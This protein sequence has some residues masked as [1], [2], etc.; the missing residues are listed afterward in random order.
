MRIALTRLAFTASVWMVDRVHDDPA[1][2]GTAP[3]PTAPPRLSHIYVLMFEV[4]YLA[5]RGHAGCQDASHLSGLEPYLH[6]IAVTAHYLSK[7]SGAA[8]QLTAFA[9]LPFKPKTAASNWQNSGVVGRLDH[10][11]VPLHAYPVP[12]HRAVGAGAIRFR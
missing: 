3:E 4:S 11:R 8:D 5:N 12:C 10:E 7:S 6:I 2:M 9:G 1:N